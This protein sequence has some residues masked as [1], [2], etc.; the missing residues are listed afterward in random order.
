M[1]LLQRVVG[2]LG[3]LHSADVGAQTGVYLA[4]S[5]DA[6]RITGKYYG[7][8]GKPR[9]GRAVTYDQEIARRLW[10]ASEALCGIVAE[11]SPR[12]PTCATA[13]GS[14]AIDVGR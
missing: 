4:S 5:P 9:R 8:S 2:F 10:G 11:G 12:L 13:C 1:H 3:I 14:F 6:A 7:H